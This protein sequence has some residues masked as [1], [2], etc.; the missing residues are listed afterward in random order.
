MKQ[1][2]YSSLPPIARNLA[3]SA[4]GW[5]KN[6]RRFGGVFPRWRQY[7]ADNAAKSATDIEE[8]QFEN[9][10]AWLREVCVRAPYY[11]SIFGSPAK[12]WAPRLRSW[13]DLARLPSLPKE[14]VKAAPEA[15]L[16]RGAGTRGLVWHLTSG[17]TG[18]P[19]RV[20]YYP[21][22]EQFEWG[23]IWGR[24]RPGV[25]RS[26]R[27]ASFSGR[28]ICDPIQHAPVL[29]RRLVI[30]A[31]CVQYL[32]P[33]YGQSSPVRRRDRGVPTGVY[34]RLQQRRGIPGLRSGHAGPPARLRAACVLRRLRAPIA[35]EPTRHRAGT[36]VSGLESRR[37]DGTHMLHH[38]A[39]VRSAPRG[40]GLLVRRVRAR[41]HRRGRQRHGGA[42]WH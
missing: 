31:T 3:A 30:V 41:R 36:E 22:N 42:D 8:E 7:F 37:A 23:M 35:V 5:R 40:P 38:R 18:S 26:D 27:Y 10:Q 2:I 20:P 6:R 13:N 14:K 11:T 12:A 17:S 15:F 1:V 9:L 16:V 25:T 28:P 19:M 39:G 34:R 33:E 29:G 4:A 24:A 32:S 21:E